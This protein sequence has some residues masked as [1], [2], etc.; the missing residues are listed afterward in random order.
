MA[1]LLLD[2]ILPGAGT[3]LTIARMADAAQ[4]ADAANRF[5]QQAASMFD[6]IDTNRDQVLSPGE[7]QGFAVAA[8]NEIERGACDRNTAKLYMFIMKMFK[9]AATMKAKG[10]NR[11]EDV[12]ELVNAFA[13]VVE[14]N[15]VKEIFEVHGDISTAL[16]N[17][18]R[19]QAIPPSNITRDEFLAA[20]REYVTRKEKKL[21]TTSFGLFF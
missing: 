12:T 8:Q 20:T 1:T 5:A 21:A 17:G 9:L 15:E 6:A 4:K 14:L 13:S 3:L 19:S 16:G 18:G 2:L 7:Q 10:I 11:S